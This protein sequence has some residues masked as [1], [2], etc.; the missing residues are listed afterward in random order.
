VAAGG[1]KMN[2]SGTTKEALADISGAKAPAS[3]KQGNHD[4]EQ[5]T[6]SEDISGAKAPASLKLSDE[7][8]PAAAPAISPGQKPRPH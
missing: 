7:T 4:K 8:S 2:F 6:L 1:V 3:L 5:T